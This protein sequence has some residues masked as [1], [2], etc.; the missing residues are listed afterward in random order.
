LGFSPSHFRAVVGIVQDWGYM[1][2]ATLALIACLALAGCRQNDNRRT[3]DRSP[4][5]AAGRAAYE[6]SQETKKAAKAAGREL[7][8][9]AK[10]AHA[11]WKDAQREHKQDHK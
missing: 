11:G 8:H 9:A 10:E 1:R 6:L 2:L 7:N 5:R 3:D 4:A